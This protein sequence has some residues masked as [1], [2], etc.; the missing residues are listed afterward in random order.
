VIHNTENWEMTLGFLLYAEPG[1]RT[2]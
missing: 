1:Y 2:L